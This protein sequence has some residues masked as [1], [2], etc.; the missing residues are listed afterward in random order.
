M[1]ASTLVPLVV[2]APM[3]VGAA[4]LAAAHAWPK[5]LPDVV[6]ILTAVAACAACTW[7][8][9]SAARH[10]P[11]AY[12]FGGWA[13]RPGLVLGIGFEADAA[14]A[15]IAAFV[16]LVVTASLVFA[17]S[18]F[19]EVH[20]HFHVLMLLFMAAMIGFCLTRDLFNLFVWFEVMS[21]AAYALTAYQLEA[22]SLAGA[23]NFIVVNSLA[24]FLMLGGIGLTYA[25][26]GQ[27]D[28]QAV[29]AAAARSP[30]DP[31]LLGGF[32]LVATALLVKAAV[33][34]FQFWLSDAHAV[35]PSPVSVVF[36]G[37]MVSLG[38][39]GLLKL[40]A[41]VFAASPQIL[42][43]FHG[44]LSGLG[45][46]TA[47]VGALM[48]WRQRHLKRLL[49]FSTIS[50]LGVMLTGIAGLSAAG[51]SA[52]LV[53]L[54]GH[55]LVKGALFMVAGLLLALRASADE[56][57]L[58]GRAK[59]LLPAGMLMALAALVLA[60][61]PWGL[62]HG[63]AE[64]IEAAG[65]LDPGPLQLAASISG[66]LAAALTGAA[67]LRASGRIFLGWGAA[68]GPEARSPSDAETEKGDRPFWLMLAPC[69][70]LVALALAPAGPAMKAAQGVTTQFAPSLHPGVL[71]AGDELRPLS[72]LAA[73]I[74][75]AGLALGRGRLPGWM[76]RAG[77]AVGDGLEGL[78]AVHDGLVGDYVVWLALGLALILGFAIPL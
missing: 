77:D 19:D 73:A 38:L 2:V 36:S 20:A 39:F 58:R 6:A 10:G 65:K 47:A 72:S 49:A 64:G 14:S 17:W 41:I 67:V 51:A 52:F 11:I 35:A 29:A 78:S 34:P 5:V 61:A 28:F 21:V 12:W 57:D 33:A 71:E 18:Y 32:A 31:A 54:V 25:R 7:I 60:G 13:P 26:A 3:L 56:I 74:L 37:V 76:R 8:A 42:S 62:L 4:L 15:A 70:A 43:L 68:A 22:D 59:D 75:F 53:Y 24:S 63:G 1:T 9:A 23:L 55:G 30:A 69:I 48:A 46:L 45:S 16:A 44:L 50:H 66:W 40:G 27:L